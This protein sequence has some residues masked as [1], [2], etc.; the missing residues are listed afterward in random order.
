VEV[1]VDIFL[2]SRSFYGLDILPFYWATFPQPEV[3]HLEPKERLFRKQPL[4]ESDEFSSFAEY[5]MTG[6]EDRSFSL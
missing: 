2:P 4:P 3:S 6:N 1:L 5:A